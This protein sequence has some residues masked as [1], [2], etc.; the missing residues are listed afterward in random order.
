V[1]V[2]GTCLKQLDEDGGGV[3]KFLFATHHRESPSKHRLHNRCSV[4]KVKRGRQPGGELDT[5]ICICIEHSSPN[6]LYD[7]RFIFY[8]KVSNQMFLESL[9]K[10]F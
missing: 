3:L 6:K 9:S 5:P 8:I 4:H 2:V 7:I 1:L 10:K